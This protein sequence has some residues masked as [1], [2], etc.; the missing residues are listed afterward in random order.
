MLDVLTNPQMWLLALVLSI[1]GSFA[2]LAN[3]YAGQRGKNTIESIYPRITQE[4]WDRVLLSYKRSLCARIDE[5]T[6][7][8]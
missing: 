4:T 2:R 5:T 7:P 8:Y 6:P 1:L 3:Y